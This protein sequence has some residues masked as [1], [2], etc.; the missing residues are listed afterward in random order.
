MSEMIPRYEAR[1]GGWG[2]DYALN[3]EDGGPFCLCTDVA[4]LEAKLAALE[5]ENERL[6]T[7][8]AKAQ[9]GQT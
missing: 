2:N 6:K 9:D 3:Q 1:T 8:L 7:E 4:A 5:A